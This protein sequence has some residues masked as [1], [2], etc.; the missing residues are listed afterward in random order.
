MDADRENFVVFTDRLKNY[1]KL[2]QEVIGLTK[3]NRSE[4][5]RG[6]LKSQLLPAFRQCMAAADRLLEYNVSVGAQRGQEIIKSCR[7]TQFLFAILGTLLFAAGF[8]VAIFKY[9][10]FPMFKEG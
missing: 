8:A 6:L 10:F 7:R 9:V 1:R 3:S 5:A 4:E 2:T